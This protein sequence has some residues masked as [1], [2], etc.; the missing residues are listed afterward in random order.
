M[1]VTAVTRDG[2]RIGMTMSSF[3][4]VSL[5]PPL[6]LFSVHKQALSFVHW[7][8][9]SH[10]AI[11][12]LCEDQEDL[13]NNFARAKGDKWKGVN[14][15]IGETGAPIL[16]G[17][18]VTFECKAHCRY[19]GGDHD[20]FIGNIVNIFEGRIVTG[21]PLLFYAGRYRQLA[22]VETAHTPPADTAELHGWVSDLNA[23]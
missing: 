3:N 22:S 5:E 23:W 4:S 9:I 18:L 1:I 21:R 15:I 12:V 10:Y 11:N 16:P 17:A 2:E 14:P 6:V 13:S 7:N 19:D 8:E 20:I